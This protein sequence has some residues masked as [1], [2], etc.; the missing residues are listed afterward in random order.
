MGDPSG[1][2]AATGSS[3]RTASAADTEATTAALADVGY[4]FAPRVQ[5]EGERLF[6]EVGELG[7]LVRDALG[8]C[9]TQQVPGQAAGQRSHAVAAQ[10]G[11]RAEPRL[12]RAR[13]ATTSRPSHGW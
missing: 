5:A 4:G 11:Q 1:A 6:L 9:S 10:L 7:A 12:A 8:A 2:R 3:A 13:A